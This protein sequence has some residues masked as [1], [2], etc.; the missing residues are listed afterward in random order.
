MG[1]D[2]EYIVRKAVDM[3]AVEQR[4]PGRP[5]KSWKGDR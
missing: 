2:E 1:R 4:P 3:E 5:R